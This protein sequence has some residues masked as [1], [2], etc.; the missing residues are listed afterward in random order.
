MFNVFNVFIML[1]KIFYNNNSNKMISEDLIMTSGT[2]GISESNNVYE[3]TECLRGIFQP[4]T[5]GQYYNQESPNNLP[6]LIICDDKLTKQ[7]RGM[8]DLVMDDRPVVLADINGEL[9]QN[10]NVSQ[11]FNVRNLTNSGADH[12]KFFSNNIDIDSE[13]KCIN[14]YDD[15][16]YQDKYKIHPNKVTPEQSPLSNYK[17]MLVKNYDKKRQYKQEKCLD[18]SER[19][20]FNV[21]ASPSNRNTVDKE[22]VHYSFNNTEYCGDWPCQRLFN[23]QTKRSTLTNPHNTHNI[24]PCYLNCN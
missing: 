15:L 8:Y 10:G 21:C 3:E 2:G 5:I 18:A 12:Q 23:N 7:N 19:Q 13:L 17:N 22:P 9:L 11:P 6:S 20:Q 4:T 16:C 24:N 14:K 1:V